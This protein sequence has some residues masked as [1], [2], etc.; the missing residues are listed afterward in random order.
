MEVKSCR[1]NLRP[2]NHTPTVLGNVWQQDFT[3]LIASPSLD[4][5]VAATPELCAVCELRRKCQGGCKAAAQVCCGNLCAPEPFLACNRK[6]GVKLRVLEPRSGCQEKA[7][8]GGLTRVGNGLMLKTEVPE[9]N[10]RE[11]LCRARPL[12]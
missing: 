11:R 4:E 8:P 3:S 5:F 9:I 7:G 1:V 10:Q 12:L 2:C 6:S